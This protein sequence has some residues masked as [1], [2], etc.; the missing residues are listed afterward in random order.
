[1][2]TEDSLWA[3]VLRHPHRCLC[4]CI[5]FWNVLLVAWPYSVIEQPVVTHSIQLDVWELELSGL[6][7]EL[8]IKDVKF[9]LQGFGVL[10]FTIGVLRFRGNLT[11][12]AF[13]LHM[14]RLVETVVVLKLTEID[15]IQGE[16]LLSWAAY[17]GRC[18]SAGDP[19]SNLVRD[20]SCALQGL[21]N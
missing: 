4:R 13:A 5:C 21:R 20:L 6:S 15:L 18:P 1:M 3:L 19:L 16:D 14:Q 12:V 10:N 17:Y 2:L 7:H 8:L 11:L 9:F